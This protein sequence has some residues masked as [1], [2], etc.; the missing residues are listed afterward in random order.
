MLVNSYQMIGLYNY[1]VSFGSNS[2]KQAGSLPVYALMLLPG[3]SDS[4]HQPLLA[5]CQLR[6]RRWKGLTVTAADVAYG[7][8][9]GHTSMASAR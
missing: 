8:E 7:C 2:G 3:A 1:T 5:L 6:T 4:Y 9:L